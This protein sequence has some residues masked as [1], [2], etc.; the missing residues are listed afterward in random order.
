MYGV[1]HGGGV[2]GEK[3]GKPLTSVQACVSGDQNRF[4]Y[5]KNKSF[6]NPNHVVS[7]SKPNHSINTALSQHKI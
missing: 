4:F 2:T 5:A 6:P 3:A 1:G 7:V